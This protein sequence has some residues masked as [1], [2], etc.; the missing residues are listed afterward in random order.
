MDTE[1][2]GMVSFLS[3]E[4]ASPRITGQN[5]QLMKSEVGAR[6]I[7]QLV[8]WY[9]REWG[10]ARDFKD[11]LI[12]LLNA[13]KF[14]GKEYTPYQIYM[15][16]LYEYFKDDLVAGG[17]IGPR[18]TA[19]DLAEFQED[20]VKKSRKILAMYNGVMIADSVGLGKTSASVES[21]PDT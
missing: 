2:A 7:L 16:A 12:E 1:A 13:S 9:D 21:L 14:G 3:N 17:K 11:D 6:A 19:V 8:E 20:A 4:K 5:R 18:G 10:E 15:K